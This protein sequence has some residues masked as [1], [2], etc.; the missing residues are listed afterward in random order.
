MIKAHKMTNEK[1][2]EPDEQDL[3]NIETKLR[4]LITENLTAREIYCLF[5]LI[6]DGSFD[7]YSFFG[8]LAQEHAPQMFSIAED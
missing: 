3:L 8:K 5:S 6:D 1:Y 7:K 4:N 2:P